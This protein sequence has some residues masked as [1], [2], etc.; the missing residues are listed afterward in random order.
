[1]QKKDIPFSNSKIEA[2][3][4]IIKHQFLLPRNL[5][6]REQLIH[7]L[8][9]DV[10]TYNIIRPQYSLIRNTSAE[11]FLGKRL[12]IGHYKAHFAS[13]RTLRVTQNQEN[14]CNGCK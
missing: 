7:A 1:M 6:N 3:N 9:E 14:R 11:T 4:K 5:E 13:Q 10:P 8:A 12:D 2:F